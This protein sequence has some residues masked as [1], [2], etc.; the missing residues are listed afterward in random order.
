LTTR[1]GGPGFLPVFVFGSVT[2]ANRRRAT[3]AVIPAKAGIHF[4]LRAEAEWIP[5]F[6]G[7]TG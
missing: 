1:E 6:A 5:A 4:A 3:I 2:R 7:M